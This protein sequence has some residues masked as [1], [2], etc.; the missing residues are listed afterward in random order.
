MFRPSHT[1]VHDTS[2]SVPTNARMASAKSSSV[3][4]GFKYEGIRPVATLKK[5]IRLVVPWQM[6]SNSIRA[7]FTEITGLS[8]YYS[9]AWIP[10]I[11]STDL[12]EMVS[13]IPTFMAVSTSRFRLQ[14]WLHTPALPDYGRQSKDFY[15]LS[16]HIMHELS[17]TWA[18]I[19]EGGNS[20]F[21]AWRV[22]FGSLLQ[23][24]ELFKETT[25][26]FT[27][28]ILL[29]AYL[30]RYLHVFKAIRS[31]KDYLRT[32]YLASQKSSALGEFRKNGAASGMITGATTNGI[33]IVSLCFLS[34]MPYIKNFFYN[35]FT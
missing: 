33:W 18:V 34:I 15:N 16:D 20:F 19:E 35:L 7:T 17:G 29:K 13:T 8:G 26:P 28:R 24:R 6:Y 11:S 30:V 9:N 2:K 14:W 4:V 3:H 32:L 22:F 31:Q 27:D 1:N 12:A 25:T 21:P 5:P 23:R 10:A